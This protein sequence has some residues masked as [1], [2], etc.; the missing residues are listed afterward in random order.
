VTNWF[1]KKN[2]RTCKIFKNNTRG[3]VL[4]NKGTSLGTYAGSR[5]RRKPSQMMKYMCYQVDV[6]KRERLYSANKF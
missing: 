1:F 5:F 6:L 3:N 4:A 2:K